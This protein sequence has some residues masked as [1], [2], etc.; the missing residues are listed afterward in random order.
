MKGENLRDNLVEIIIFAFFSLI[1]I[2]EHGRSLSR[3]CKVVI[4][5]DEENLLSKSMGLTCHII[6]IFFTLTAF[7]KFKESFTSKLFLSDGKWDL[8]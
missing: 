1:R 3:I 4:I 7:I 6:F 5:A 8:I 2:E